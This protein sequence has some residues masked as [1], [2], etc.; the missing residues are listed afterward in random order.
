MW[1]PRFMLY[2]MLFFVTRNSIASLLEEASHE[3]QSHTVVINSH[4]FS[5]VEKYV[6]GSFS[7][8]RSPH[9][10]QRIASFFFLKAIQNET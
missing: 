5:P 3:F 7:H 9:Q 4:I 8:I 6:Q 2:A 1:Y 10:I